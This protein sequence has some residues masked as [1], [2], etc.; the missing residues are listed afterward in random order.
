[1]IKKPILENDNAILENDKTSDVLENMI[2][3]NCNAILIFFN[4]IHLLKKP[5]FKYNDL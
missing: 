4:W 3:K 2:L 5:I 1:M